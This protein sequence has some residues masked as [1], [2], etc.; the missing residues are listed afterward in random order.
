MITKQLRCQHPPDEEE[1][2]EEVQCWRDLPV[3]GYIIAVLTPSK[4]CNLII[5]T[6]KLKCV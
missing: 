2:K 3:N 5:E 1:V 4:K 6:E